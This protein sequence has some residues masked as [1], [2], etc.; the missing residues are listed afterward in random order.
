MLRYE[1]TLLFS[2]AIDPALDLQRLGMTWTTPALLDSTLTL[3]VML[4]GL[5]YTSVDVNI[6]LIKVPRLYGPPV[7]D[8]GLSFIYLLAGL[9]C[10]C[11]GLDLSPYRTFYALA[12]IG[13][14]TAGIRIR[15]TQ[16]RGRGKRRFHR[17]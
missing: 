17:H 4:H 16:A 3:G 6:S 1:C 14:A 8:A 2:S 10:Y 9:Y 7:P 13:V 5:F 12:L 11:A 15:D